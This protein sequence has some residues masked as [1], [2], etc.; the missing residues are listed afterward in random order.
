MN[1]ELLEFLE[2]FLSTTLKLDKAGVAALFEADGSPKP[3][4]LTQLLEKNK[5]HI[6]TLNKGRTFDD[7]YKA[8][9]K[10]VKTEF[11]KEL[12]ESFGIDSDKVGVELITEIIEVKTPKGEALTD[13]TVKKHKT[14]LDLK[15]SVA[16]QVKEAVKAE[17]QLHETYKS[18]VERKETITAVKNEALKIF[19]EAKVVL[20]KDAAKAEKLKNLFLKEIEAG[21]YRIDNGKVI[22]LNEKGEDQQDEQGHRKDFTTVIKSMINETFETEVG[23]PKSSAGNSNAGGGGGGA[24]ITVKDEEDFKKQYLAA[25]DSKTKAEIYSAWEKTQAGATS[26]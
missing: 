2:S 21:N 3:D 12:K 7:G 15:E 18:Q 22:L 16:N 6:A 17:K 23:D 9:E 10:K 24:T 5:A 11:E 4:A 1:K 14:Y 8:A 13:E 20:P 25:P 19:N 26:K